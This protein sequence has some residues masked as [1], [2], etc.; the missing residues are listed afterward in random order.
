MRARR[1]PVVIIPAELLLPN[2]AK[3]PSDACR[4]CGGGGGG[5]A[6]TVCDRW[7]PRLSRPCW[8]CMGSG[9]R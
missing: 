7:D 5:G 6:L 3:L 4:A 2:G 8:V 1:D 9:R